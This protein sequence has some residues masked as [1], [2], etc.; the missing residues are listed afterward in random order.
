MPYI[1]TL[2]NRQ[3]AVTPREIFGE[4]AFLL[5][6]DITKY[7]VSFK[8]AGGDT[9]G[10][11]LPVRSDEGRDRKKRWWEVEQH[12]DQLNLPFQL[13][14]PAI[15]LRREYV[16]HDQEVKIE[17]QYTSDGERQKRLLR[18]NDGGCNPRR[19]NVIA[20]QLHKIIRYLVPDAA[21]ETTILTTREASSLLFVALENGLDI[22]PDG[23]AIDRV[24]GDVVGSG[25]QILP[26]GPRPSTSCEPLETCRLRLR[27]NEEM[28]FY[29]E[30]RRLRQLRPGRPT[31]EECARMLNQAKRRG[32]VLTSTGDLYD[33]VSGELI[34]TEARL[35]ASPPVEV[36]RGELTLA[37][38]LSVSGDVR[39]LDG[40]IYCFYVRAELLDCIVSSVYFAP[41]HAS[42]N[43]RGTP[44]D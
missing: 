6:V 42:F 2:E 43:V 33:K 35:D 23:V 10:V 8:Q 11:D 14:Q 9:V 21:E 15:I 31:E 27:D 28:S 29:I 22:R 20:L 5:D 13:Y 12:P 18:H 16:S 25:F 38:P 41:T 39:L 26:S 36:E 3:P 40:H 19:N 1:R 24:T 44:N 7:L 34:G 4:M 17:V 32:M 30:R 37:P